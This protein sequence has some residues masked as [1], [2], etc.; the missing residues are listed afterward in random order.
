LNEL[1]SCS[2]GEQ[3]NG[4]FVIEAT[5]GE[6]ERSRRR[7]IEPVSIV[8]HRPHRSVVSG[9]EQAERRHPDGQRIA[10]G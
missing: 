7:R 8:D 3:C 2:H 9:R 4:A 6:R 5:G 10:V 1:G